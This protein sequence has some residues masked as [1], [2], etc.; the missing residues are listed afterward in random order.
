MTDNDKKSLAVLSRSATSST[1]AFNACLDSGTPAGDI[2]AYDFDTIKLRQNK[3][4][5]F[6]GKSA[7]ALIIDNGDYYLI[8]FKT[9]GIAVDDILR[10]VYDSA[11]VLVEMG[12]LTWQGCKEHLT[13]IVVGKEMEKRF[14]QAYKTPLSVCM[15]PGYRQ[16][17]MD[18][19]VVSG[20]VAKEVLLQ[21]IQDFEKYAAAKKWC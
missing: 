1:G 17:N 20:Q 15:Q 5:P 10:K 6:K 18:P 11:L 7:D 9:G 2:L 3:G 14:Q 12:A 21:T 19:R 8:E 16:V 13:F 4:R